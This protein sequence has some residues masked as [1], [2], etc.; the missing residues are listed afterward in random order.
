M[1]MQS[2]TRGSNSWRH[3]SHAPRAS[4]SLERRAIDA[5]LQA[6]VNFAARFGGQDDP[7]FGLSQIGRIELRRLLVVRMHLHG[8]RLLAIEKLEQQRKLPLR[9][10][11]AEERRAILRHQLVQRLAG[12]R[13]IDDDALIVA[14]IDDFPAFGAALQVAD[15]LAQLGAQPP[16]APQILAQNRPKSKWR[17]CRH[18]VNQMYLSQK[19]SPAAAY[20][21]CTRLAPRDAIPLAERAD[22]TALSPSARVVII[23]NRQSHRP[24]APTFPPP[25]SPFPLARVHRQYNE[26]L[27]EHT[28]M[29]FGEHLEELRRRW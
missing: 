29:T 9:M 23:A 7:G 1:K 21:K 18:N 6:R 19:Q 27:F 5:R 2:P 13:P 11:P 14:V 4:C 12:E 15:R 22:Y 25:L 16:A 17:K 24:V 8:E 20:C 26:D 10:V 3:S 28:K